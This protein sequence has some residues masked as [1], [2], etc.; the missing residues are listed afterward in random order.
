MPNTPVASAVTLSDV[1]LTRRVH[2]SQQIEVLDSVTLSAAEGSTVAIVG[3]SGCGKSTL[4][5][6]ACGMLKPTSGTVTAQPAAM[7][8]QRDL[9]LPWATALDNAALALRAAGLSRG[10]AR[11]QAADWFPRLGIA[12]FENVRPAQ[13]SG[14][15]R[16]R[17]AFARTLLAGRP[18]IALDEPFAALDALSRIEARAWLSDALAAGGRTALL[19]T[20]DVEEAVLLADRIIVLSPRPA[21]V[22]ESLSVEIA[23][24]RRRS[25]PQVVAMRQSILEL[26]GAGQ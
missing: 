4:L 22:V 8:A 13:L 9:L 24:P 26:L 25:D 2:R 23:K 14:G 3:P 5:E 7:M 1:V 19:V 18:V 10:D 11:D 15:M 16:Q 21:K 20:H 12:G 17:V 6:V